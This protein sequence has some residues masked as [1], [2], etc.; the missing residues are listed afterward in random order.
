MGHEWSATVGKRSSGRNCPYC[1]GEIPIVGK[2]DLKTLFPNIAAEWNKERN[3]K[4]QPE[5]YLPKSGKRVW[6]MCE[7]CRTEWRARI[8]D[9]TI[10]KSN[11]PNCR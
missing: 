2:N 3:R 1:A 5:N 8:A 10:G 9:R 6:W 11:C 7:M 4:M